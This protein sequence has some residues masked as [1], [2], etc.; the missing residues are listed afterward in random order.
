VTA[1]STSGDRVGMDWMAIRMG[2]LEYH[3]V[4]LDDNLAAETKMNE[5]SSVS[6]E[7]LKRATPS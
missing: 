7:N 4:Y 6:V 3:I 5:T 2:G 1:N